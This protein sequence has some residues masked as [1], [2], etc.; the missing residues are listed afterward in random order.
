MNEPL[1]RLCLVLHNHQPIGNFDSVCEQA[2]QES[3]LPFL[4]AFEPFA[5][6]RISLHTSGSLMQ[7]LDDHHPEYLD[8]L[9]GLVAAGRIEIIGGAYY[10]PILTMIP[11]R[12]RLG[13]ITRYTDFLQQ[14]LGGKVLGMWIPE[15]VW[16]ASLTTDIA[17]AGIQYTVLDDF[18]FACAGLRAEQLDGYYVTEDQG[19]MLRVFPGSEKLRYL[20]PFATPQETV[21]YCRQIGQRRPGSVIVFGDDGEKF[22]TWPNTFKH[23]YQDGWLLQF[24]TALTENQSW[25]RTSTLLEAVE[26]TAPVG[27]IYLPDASYREMTEW[28]YPVAKQREYSELAHAG[29]QDPQWPLLRSHMRGGFW[30]NFKVKYPESNEMYARMMYVSDRLNS[31]ETSSARSQDPQLENARKHLYQAQCNCAYWHGAFGGVYLPHLRNAVFAHLIRAENHLRQWQQT[32]AGVAWGDDAKASQAIECHS[33]DFDFDGHA[34]VRLANDLVSLWISPQRGGQLYEMDLHSAAHNFLATLQRRPEVYHDKIVAGQSQAAND[35][36]SIHDRV[37]LKRDDLDQFLQYDSRLR[38]T[39]VDHF[40]DENVEMEDVARG[41]ALERGDFADGAYRATIRRKS[42][43]VQVM[44]QRDGNA[45]GI[46]LKVTK[47]ITLAANSSELQI[48]Y[49]IEG[50]PAGQ[51]FHFGVEFNFSGLPDNQADRFFAT[52][53]PA[54]AIGHLGTQLD[55]EGGQEIQLH[56]QWAGLQVRLSAD[57][58]THF[59]GF[60]IQTVSQSESGFE[61]VHQSVVVQPHWIVSGDDAGRWA[62]RMRLDLAHRP[63]VT[64]AQE[65][66]GAMLSAD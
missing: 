59:W 65:L 12:D 17:S 5:N 60:P 66:A 18:H 7:W 15:R 8:R 58:T 50:I 30:R 6:L 61:L 32:N 19:Q 10:E 43:R 20:I 63:Q 1:I 13:Q 14:R 27:K 51:R 62:V 53:D 28:A 26:T 11:S 3:Y 47:G 48:D 44:M 4:N 56:D 31:L 24:F 57:Q 2:Y 22:G 41:I 21:D 55:L 29:E 40:W 35:T 54:V 34:E 36:A 45:W 46:P 9:A 49:M 25:L 33:Q 52:G 42:D 16:E 37:V 23:V 39:L 38:K 64:E